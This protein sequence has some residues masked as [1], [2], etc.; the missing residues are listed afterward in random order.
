MFQ[1]K[2]YPREW[3][4]DAGKKP[5]GFVAQLQVASN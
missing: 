5:G 3:T 1:L 4:P 2:N